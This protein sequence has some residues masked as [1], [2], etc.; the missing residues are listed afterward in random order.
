[1]A[2]PSLIPA[3]G[4]ILVGGKS[5]RFGSD[6]ALMSL[7]GEPVAA[8]LH[9]RLSAVLSEVILIAD[10]SDKLD[11]PG[12]RTYVDL[13]PE[14]GPLGGLY[15]ALH[16]AAQEYCFL[17]ACDLPFLDADL[18]TAL[19]E[20]TKGADV[21]VPVHEGRVEPLAGFYHRRCYEAVEK[22]VRSERRDMRSFWDSAEVRRIDVAKL[23]DPERL[24]RLFFNI[25]TP[26]HYRQA[27]KYRGKE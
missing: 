25:N 4:A 18:I 20:H 23:F 19:W 26:E 14:R 16:Y 21:V 12:S 10:R 2:G 8:R 22:A 6:K 1:M 7:E 5:L 24:E 15:T 17:T 11:L 27:Q 3:A 13:L 9:A